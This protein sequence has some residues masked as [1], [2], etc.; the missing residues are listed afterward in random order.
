MRTIYARNKP[1]TVLVIT[2]AKARI[3]MFKELALTNAG[4]TELSKKYGVS[5][6]RARTTAGQII[7]WLKRIAQD[8][9]DEE[10]ETITL[11]R[12]TYESNLSV[13]QY[14]DAYGQ[15]LINKI[16]YYEGL[17]RIIISD[18]VE[19]TESELKTIWEP[20]PKS[21]KLTN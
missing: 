19:G 12:E 1:R 17:G 18:K 14:L 7:Y 16:E 4:Y 3:D 15:F 9:K 21:A 6:D 5:K 2:F 11:R 13:R 8:A 10:M 20:K